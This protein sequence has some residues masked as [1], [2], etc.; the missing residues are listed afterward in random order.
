MARTPG[1]RSHRSKKKR[2]TFA[3]APVAALAVIVPLMN[4]AGAATP[5]K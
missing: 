2:I 4:S 1:K 5:P 3:L